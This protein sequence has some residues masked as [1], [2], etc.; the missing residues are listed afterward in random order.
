LIAL[1]ALVPSVLKATTH[2]AGEVYHVTFTAPTT[3]IPTAD[4]LWLALLVQPINQNPF[5]VLTS[6]PYVGGQRPGTATDAL[7]PSSCYINFSYISPTSLWDLGG[8]TYD[9]HTTVIDFGQVT[10]GT[11][12]AFI[13]V[14]VTSRCVDISLADG[15]GL[16]GPGLRYILANSPNDGTT[17][18]P[19]A[20]FDIRQ[21]DLHILSPLLYLFITRRRVRDAG[22]FKEACGLW[23]KETVGERTFATE[24]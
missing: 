6:S 23:L 13:D 17:V 8:A 12:D 11:S 2:S 10:Q 18:L 1:I 4:T 14:S 15:F 21:C 19:S 20:N 9:G 24:D 7:N 16:W 3:A 22:E 5:G